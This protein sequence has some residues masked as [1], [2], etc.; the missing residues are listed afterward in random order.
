MSEK[1][2]KQKENETKELAF[3]R[4]EVRKAFNRDLERD[5]LNKR[6]EGEKEE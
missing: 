5:Q 4:D 3:N 6:E 2:L 1:E